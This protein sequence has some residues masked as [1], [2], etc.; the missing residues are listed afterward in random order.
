MK[1]FKKQKKTIVLVSHDYNTISN[2]CENAILIYKGEIAINGTSTQVINQYHAML[3]SKK[4]ELVS[5]AASNE[6]EAKGLPKPK[7]YGT[8]DAEIVK[9][10]L[11][12]ETGEKTTKIKTGEKTVILVEIVFNN[13]V[14][15]PIFGMMVTRHD[16]FYVYG[17]NTRA[18]HMK[19]NTFKKGE[20]VKTKFT[21]YM[22]LNEGIYYISPAVAYT[23]GTRF[24]D[25]Q[26]EALTFSVTKDKELYGLVDLTSDIEVIK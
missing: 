16:G 12:N 6:P 15:N 3:S 5:S 11:Y 8:M 24:C 9:T 14:T 19:F 7:R 13:E 26:D 17:T 20:K 10:E 4:K 1:E 21:Q 25:W 23:D 22:R 18:M 2:F